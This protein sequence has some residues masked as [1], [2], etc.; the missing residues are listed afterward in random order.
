MVIIK[1]KQR[2]PLIESVGLLPPGKFTAK[3]AAKHLKITDKQA[4]NLLARMA[5]QDYVYALSDARPRVYSRVKGV[6]EPDPVLNPEQPTEPSLSASM[7]RLLG[8]VEQVGHENE[9]MRQA[10]LQARNTIDAALKELGHVGS[11]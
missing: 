9:M 4:H 10:L 8:N 11:K 1:K 5:R 3:Q 6:R 2:R 7:E